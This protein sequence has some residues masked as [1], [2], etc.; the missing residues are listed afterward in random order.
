MELKWK[1][2]MMSKCKNMQ[3]EDRNVTEHEQ[4]QPLEGGIL[5]DLRVLIYPFSVL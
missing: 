5:G 3:E 2:R 4:R 1:N